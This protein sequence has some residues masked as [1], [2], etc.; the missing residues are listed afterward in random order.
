[1]SYPGEGHGDTQTVGGCDYFGVADRASRL[2]D[3]GGTGLGNGF[4]AVGKGEEGI[5]GGYAAGE[6]QDGLHSSEAGRV[7]PAH[8]AGADA[9]GLAVAIGEASI[10]DGV[11]FDV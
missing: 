11:G 7:D 5:G 9:D 2:D 1:M 8:L 4:E 3:G 6:R 10:D